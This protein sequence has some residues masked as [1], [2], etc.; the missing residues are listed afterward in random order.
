[1]VR[2]LWHLGCA[3]VLLAGAAV[4]LAAVVIPRLAGAT[5]YTVLTGSMSP[6]LPPGTLVVTR[7]VAPDDIGVGSVIT[8]QLVSGK[9]VF[10]THR[11]VSQAVD[12]EGQPMFQT[13]GDGNSA[14]DRTWVRPLQVRGELW[15][16]V[17]HVG[18]LSNTI[19]SQDRQLLVY[20][21]AAALLLYAALEFGSALRDRRRAV[22]AARHAATR[23]HH[24]PHLPHLPHRAH[25]A[26]EHER[27]HAGV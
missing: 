8:Y 14:P 26:G 19:T 11:V 10:V 9:P 2:R 25:R 22:R 24:L 3:A 7:P 27:E 4:L 12:D 20:L 13:Q 5:P 17:P 6:D 23:P 1:M 16:A 21:L 15:Y 18:Y